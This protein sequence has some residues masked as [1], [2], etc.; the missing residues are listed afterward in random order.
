MEAPVD[1]RTPDGVADATLYTPEGAG[2]WPGAIMLVDIMGVRPANQGMARRLADAGFA[3]LLPNIYYRTSRMPVFKTPPTFDEKGRAHL[4][5]MKATLT[6]GRM[7]MDGAAY[8][9]FLAAYPGVNARAKLGVA[10]YCMTGSM[11]VRTAAARPDRI[12]AAASFHGGH[13]CTDA[14]DSPHLLLPQIKAALYFGHATD[15]G[16]MPADA[17]ARFEAALTAWGG[18]FESETYPAKHGWTVPGGPVYDEGDAERA[19]GNLVAL[20]KEELG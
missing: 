3:V 11:A 19:W 12:G 18:R 10:G 2:P 5:E 9:D 14:P 15:D 16:S 17:I 20:F 13:L 4:M 6:P 7:A 8:A 1:V